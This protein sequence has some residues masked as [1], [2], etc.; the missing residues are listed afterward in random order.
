LAK[1]PRSS[2]H[3]QRSGFVE[4]TLVDIN[5]TLEQSLF[6][7]QNA[8]KQGLLQGLDPRLKIVA[9][10]LLVLAVNLSHNILIIL[11]LYFLALWLA[12]FSKISLVF[13]IK[14]VWLLIPFFT[15]IVALPA[16]FITPGSILVHLPL[17][18]VI[19]NTG[20]MTAAFL[21]LRVGTSVSFAVLLILTT[22]WNSVLKALG[23]LRVPAVVILI[24]GMTYRY[25][26]LLLHITN[27]MFLSR[28]S[29]LL[30]RMN[31]S[32]ER[33]LVAATSGKLLNKS[34]QVSSEVFLAM[35]SR[36]FR[37][38][39]RTMDTFKMRWR[40]WLSGGVVFIT[41]GLAIWL[42]RL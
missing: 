3:T 41:I 7:E 22:P 10:L 34:L 40:D 28:K 12:F 33:H 4:K 15:G 5:N 37:N 39:P 21:L 29:R 2:K 32:E 16:L 23:V 26:H 35:Q 20:V 18:L 17:G 38:Y 30:R 11:V 14:R 9:L 25:V 6:A 19:T 31:G 13:F 27:D 42:G 8:R 1:F 36:G 24:L